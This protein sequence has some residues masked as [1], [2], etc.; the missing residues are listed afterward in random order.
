MQAELKKEIRVTDYELE[1]LDKI[2]AGDLR[3]RNQLVMKYYPLVI[4]IARSYLKKG[5]SMD[6]LIQEGVIGLIKGSMKFDYMQ[7][8]KFSTYVCYWI[9]QAMHMSIIKNVNLVKVPIRKTIQIAQI[10]RYMLEEDNMN[11]DKK[12]VCKELEIQPKL[13]DKLLALAKGTLSL[14]Y[15]NENGCEFSDC[16][17]SSEDIYEELKTNNQKDVMMELLGTFLNQ[18]EKRIIIMRF[19]IDDGVKKSLRVVGAS[20][21]ISPEGVR[22]IENIAMKKL[23]TSE[24][25]SM[26]SQVR[27]ND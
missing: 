16:I 26:F 14:D 20:I 8:V 2:Q 21:G 22:R 10:R 19:G 25:R 13:Y 17:C 3:A 7:G 6:D 15:R 23:M 27:Y 5:M 12:V 24:V 18:K 9:K 11:K 4:K 1:L